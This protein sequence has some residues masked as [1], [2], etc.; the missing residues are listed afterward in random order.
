M[1]LL[2]CETREEQKRSKLLIAELMTNEVA[3]ARIESF[4]IEYF[5]D[6]EDD[7]ECRCSDLLG[8]FVGLIGRGGSYLKA[9]K[10]VK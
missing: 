7:G 5:C 3:A 4:N 1:E 9:L 8:P 6:I 10:H 2:I